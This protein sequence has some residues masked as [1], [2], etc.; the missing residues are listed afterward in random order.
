M[1]LVTSEVPL[2]YFGL[3]TL[4]D[5]PLGLNVPGYRT[6]CISHFSYPVGQESR[7][8]ALSDWGFEVKNDTNF[9]ILTRCM[10]AKPGMEMARSVSENV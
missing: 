2:A 8:G 4:E 6:M 5:Q 1:L 7:Y 3:A 10:R 9:Q